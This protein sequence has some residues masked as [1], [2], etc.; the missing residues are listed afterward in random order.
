MTLVKQHRRPR[1]NLEGESGHLLVGRKGPAVE[2]GFA[3]AMV[4]AEPQRLVA[5][6][7]GAV[8]LTHG[9][10]PSQKSSQAE[11]H[12]ALRQIFLQRSKSRTAMQHAHG[13]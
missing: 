10:G 12:C 3:S 2:M 8:D 5:G 4:P 7:Y 9:V 6:M 1:R 11:S 13:S